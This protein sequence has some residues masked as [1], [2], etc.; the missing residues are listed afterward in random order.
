MSLSSSAGCNPTSNFSAPDPI[1]ILWLALRRRDHTSEV[2]ALVECLDENIIVELVAER[3]PVATVADVTAHAGRCDSCRELIAAAASVLLPSSDGAVDGIAATIPRRRAATGSDGSRHSFAAG[4]SIGRYRVLEVLGAG[5]MGVVYGAF[6]PQL[7][8]KVALKLV[9]A[10]FAALDVELRA[11]LVREAQAMARIRHPNVITVFDVGT[12]DERLFVAMEVIDGPTLSAWQAQR[13]RSVADILAVFGAAGRG[14]AAAHAAGLVHRDFKPDNILIGADGHV[15]VTDFGLARPLA[16]PAGR[17]H[18]TT[19]GQDTPPDQLQLTQA[20]AVVGTPAYMAP[21]QMRGAPPDERADQFSFCVALFEAL[22]GVRPFPGKALREL[23]RAILDGHRL[24]L[25][26]HGV[27][28]A[29][30]RAL[31]RGLRADPGTRFPS[32]EA[33][34]AALAPRPRQA[35][36]AVALALA[37]TA[38]GVV[39]W[40]R[41]SH[42]DR[43]GLCRGAPA[44]MAEVWDGPRRAAVA[45]MLTSGRGARGSDSWRRVAAALDGWSARWQALYTD[46]CEATHVRGEQSEALLDLRMQCLEQ[47]RRETGELTR[48][49]AGDASLDD[50]KAT[51]AAQQLAPLDACADLVA[52][53]RPR[54]PPREIERRLGP[55]RQQWAR[56]R[57]EIL[58]GS[59]HQALTDAE[60]AAA[61]ARLLDASDVEA[62]ATT[63]AAVAQ[64]CLGDLV[65]AHATLVAAT[66]IAARAHDEALVTFDA[67]QLIQIDAQQADFVDADRWR[68]VA[69][70]AAA[71][72]AGDLHADAEREFSLGVLEWRRGRLSDAEA[73]HRRAAALLDRLPGDAAFARARNLGQLAAVL[74]DEAQYAEAARLNR[75]AHGYF[76]ALLGPESYTTL[77]VEENIA[78]DEWEQGDYAAALAGER[79]FLAHLGENFPSHSSTALSNYGWT[80]LEAGR[81]AE[82]FAPFRRALGFAEKIEGGHDEEVAFALSG[83]GAA[84]VATGQASLAL[85][86]LSEALQLQTT[87][88]MAPDR[89]QTQLALAEALRV[90]GAS[91]AR[92]V[93]LAVEARAYLASHPLGARRARQLA[94]ADAWLAHHQRSR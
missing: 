39:G 5:G 48:I 42:A 16:L 49:L 26:R 1:T 46:A 61:A 72:A 73:H 34:L 37:V 54:H 31:S 27:P 87:P 12:F 8:R 56:A 43:A 91:T 6:D 58:A 20:G 29:V 77:S 10:D 35:P 76:L 71:R 40:R 14:L 25:R 3:L 13:G 21:E 30:R 86:R 11:R 67:S 69:T 36:V 85:P 9:R 57:A 88:E 80:L 75:R 92:S 4:D 32:M 7:Q 33:L 66:L 44:K 64:R 51:Q 93:A 19:T 79:R 53:G 81:P 55:A 89:A 83:L 50:D 63:Q 59:C 65:S 62:N 15:C 78:L 74:G 18:P 70:D 24:R 2:R 45:S 22:Y 60:E 28:A 17:A 38:V 84:Q 94:D 47:R 23:E 52:L 41:A 82:A 68:L 90:T